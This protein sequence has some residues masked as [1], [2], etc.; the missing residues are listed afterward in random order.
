MSETV[1]QASVKQTDETVEIVRSVRIGRLI[2]V[3]A[4]VGAVVAVASTLSMP[5]AEEALYT[6]G[7]IAGFMLVVGAVIGMA[8]GT[9]LAL[10]LNILARRK[11]GQA[12]ATHKDVEVEA[13][14]I[15]TPDQ[16]PTATEASTVDEVVQHVAS[17]D[18]THSSIAV[19]D[20]SNVTG[21]TPARSSNADVQ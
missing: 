16:A 3:G 8:L 19:E 14:V 2:L 21:Q 4:V 15:D 10:I 11:R 9:F 6:M 12:V 17:G 5:M 13:L 7:Q 18:N 20:A 1:E